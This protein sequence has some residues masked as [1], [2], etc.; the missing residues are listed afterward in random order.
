VFGVLGIT[1][2]DRIETVICCCF[3]METV[4]LAIESEPRVVHFPDADFIIK[5]ENTSFHVNKKMLGVWSKTFQRFFDNP[6]WKENATGIFEL[7]DCYTKAFEEILSF[8]YP[9]TVEI[10]RKNVEYLFEISDKY[11]FEQ[12]KKNLTVFLKLSYVERN[13]GSSLSDELPIKMGEQYRL[14]P[15]YELYRPYLK[16]SHCK[17]M[18]TVRWRKK[19]LEAMV[20]SCF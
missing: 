6:N 20:K 16:P 12:I 1:T 3:K 4:D 8:I 10:D 13:N 2:P 15:I 11:D 14:A 7:K 19:S 18:K 17:N 5:V 9:A